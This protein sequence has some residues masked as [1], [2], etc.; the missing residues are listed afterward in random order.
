MFRYSIYPQGR[1]RQSEKIII[2]KS[3]YSPLDS[4]A[5]ST[6]STLSGACGRACLSSCLIIYFSL[7]FAGIYVVIPL[8]LAISSSSYHPP[9]LFLL[10]P[11]LISLTISIFVF[12]CLIACG[13][14]FCVF[15]IGHLLSFGNICLSLFYIS[16]WL[17]LFSVLPFEWSIIC[18]PLYVGVGFLLIA[19]VWFLVLLQKSS[20][21]KG[22]CA[23]ADISA[24]IFGCVDGESVL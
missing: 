22:S 19:L 17:K 12:W 5:S 2:F 11:I 1:A 21:K 9:S 16:E 10:A 6:S 18:I 14:S 13:R 23:S 3:E 15:R 7:L 4:P 8:G 24:I 20:S